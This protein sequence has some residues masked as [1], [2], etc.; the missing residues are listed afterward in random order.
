MANKLEPNNQT[1]QKSVVDHGRRR[2]LNFVPFGIFAGIAGTL[3][4]AAFRFLRPAAAPTRE[5]KWVD[6]M[7]MAHIKGDKPM[8]CA[9][10]TERVAGWSTTLEEQQIFILPG[11]DRTALSSACPHEGCNVMW[12]DETNDFFCPCHDSFFAPD[13]TRAGGP[14][15]RGL[16]PLPSREKDGMLQVQYQSFVTNK[17]ERLPRV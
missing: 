14:A 15:R 16:D 8:M 1:T 2:F 4:V 13:G 10:T 5:A 3:A 17:V 6:A 9:I 7:P 12:R 11:K